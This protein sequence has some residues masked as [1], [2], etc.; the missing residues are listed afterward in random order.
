MLACP[1]HRPG[2]NLKGLAQARVEIPCPLALQA[3]LFYKLVF[4]PFVLLLHALRQVQ[5]HSSANLAAV[6]NCNGCMIAGFT[7]P[8]VFTSMPGEPIGCLVAVAPLSS[9]TRHFSCLVRPTPSLHRVVAT[10]DGQ[11]FPPNDTSLGKVGPRFT[12]CLIEIQTR[13]TS[14]M[15]LVQVSGDTAN[16]SSGK[17]G[18][19]TIWVGSRHDPCAPCAALDPHVAKVRA[20]HFSRS[21]GAWGSDAVAL[22]DA[23]PTDCL[24]P[25]APISP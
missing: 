24:D 10:G 15:M 3:C 7:Y 5:E 19:S 11:D 25:G 8:P 2:A 16:E 9:W 20:M 1:V 18:G 4:G 6:C 22:G 17:Q 14:C 23:S 12:D 13:S 21:R